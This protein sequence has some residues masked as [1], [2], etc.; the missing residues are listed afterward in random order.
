MV[1]ENFCSK[2]DVTFVLADYVHH[3]KVGPYQVSDGTRQAWQCPECGAP[4]LSSTDV[5]R[6]ER[7]AAET[8]LRKVPNVKGGA[9]GFARRAMG[10]K[11]VEL[12]EL[13]GVEEAAISRWENDRESIPKQT[14]LAVVALLDGFDQA[15]S[16]EAFRD[17]VLVQP[18]TH[19]VLEVPRRRP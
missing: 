11:Q 2:C 1:R 18:E 9:L 19:G 6:Y 16:V 10:L 7:R 12:A 8:V 4:D 15:G 17:Q 5:G 14:Q 13:L 3:A